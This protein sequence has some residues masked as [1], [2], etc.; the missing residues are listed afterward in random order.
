MSDPIEVGARI[1]PRIDQFKS[2]INFDYWM[3]NIQKIREKELDK[4][5]YDFGGTKV[6]ENNILDYLS[7]FEPRASDCDQ[8]LENI[9]LDF[10]NNLSQ[11][12]K[13]SEVA[14]LQSF[15]TKREN[16]Y[17]RFDYGVVPELQ[18]HDISISYFMLVNNY[19]GYA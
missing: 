8:L 5:R 13:K 14:K 2:Y 6:I 19:S 9:P 10:S 16:N 15:L 7:S 17:E 3:V 18:Y 1:L 12:G 11:S 4:V